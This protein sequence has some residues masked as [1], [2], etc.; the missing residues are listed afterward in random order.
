M[1]TVIFAVDI[2]AAGDAATGYL[3]AAIGVGGVDRG[4]ALEPARPSTQPARVPSSPGPVVIAGGAALL[5]ALGSTLDRRDASRSPWPVPA[6]S[7]SRSLRATLLQR[8]TTDAV[9]GRAVGT[10]VYD[11]HGR[12]GARARSCFP[13]LV[14][15]RRR[16]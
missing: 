13:V 10:M 16:R 4:A 2:L 11:R 8:V 12:G 1:L 9:R 3:N 5:G 7:S 15:S 6:T 14:V